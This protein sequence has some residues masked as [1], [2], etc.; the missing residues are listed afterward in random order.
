[1]RHRLLTDVRQEML[2]AQVTHQPFDFPRPT[3]AS[4]RNGAALGGGLMQLGPSFPYIAQSKI[5]KE[6]R[7][8]GRQHLRVRPWTVPLD[9]A[10]VDMFARS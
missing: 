3:I 1:M 4:A 7:G 9:N 2:S 6:F 10:H 5:K 8:G